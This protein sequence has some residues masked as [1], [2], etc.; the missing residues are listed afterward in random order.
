MRPKPDVLRGSQRQ[1]VG[2]FHYSQ[3][4]S[5]AGVFRP[6]GGI[7]RREPTR[8]HLIRVLEKWWHVEAVSD[9]A[10][11]PDLHNPYTGDDLIDRIMAAL[12]FKEKS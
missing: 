3:E 11:A 10:A 6:K 9:G 4:D 2:R 7:D 1:C 5:E 12:S 8:G